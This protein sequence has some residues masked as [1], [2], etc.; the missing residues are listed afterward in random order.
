MPCGVKWCWG[1]YQTPGLREGFVSSVVLL[2]PSSSVRTCASVEL[3]LQTGKMVLLFS[4]PSL[5][6]LP[7]GCV[8]LPR[9]GFTLRLV[10]TFLTVGKIC[11]KTADTKLCLAFSCVKQTDQEKPVG[12][13][14]CFLNRLQGT[15]SQVTVIESSI[16]QLCGAYQRREGIADMGT[17]EPVSVEDFPGFILVASLCCSNWVKKTK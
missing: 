6:L 8:G 17:A 7:E 14:N 2:Q 15:E 3:A 9:Y 1:E 13:C 11:A 5:C 10:L 12:K 4:D 16:L